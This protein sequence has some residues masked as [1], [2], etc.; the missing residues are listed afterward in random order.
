LGSIESLEKDKKPVKQALKSTGGVAI[1]IKGDKHIMFGRHFQLTDNLTS[2]MT[3]KSID[4]LKEY[5]RDEMTDDY[6]NL[7][8]ELKAKFEII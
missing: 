4:C 1:R 7:V 5:Y 2:I 3:R 8:R 6:W